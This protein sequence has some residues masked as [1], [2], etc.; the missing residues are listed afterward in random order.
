MLDKTEERAVKTIRFLA[1]ASFATV[2]ASPIH[3]M[4]WCALPDIVPQQASDLERLAPRVEALTGCARQS[5]DSAH[6]A[7][8]VCE[9]DP[10]TD[11]IFEGVHIN[12]F[13][14][15]G[16][17][18]HLVVL[19]MGMTDLDV[20]RRCGQRSV[21]DGDKFVAG[22]VALRDRLSFGFSGPRL[23][24]TSVISEGMSA[25]VSD[26][27]VVGEDD[28]VRGFWQGLHGITAEQYPS[29]SVK[30]AGLSP[31]SS[32]VYSIAQAFQNR[33]STVRQSEEI[34]GTF[35]KWTLS[36]PVGLGGVREVIVEGFVRHVLNADYVLEST[37][38]YERFIGLLDA[39]Y[40]RSERST[41]EGC[42]YRWWRSGRVSIRGEHCPGVSDTL[43]FMNDVAGDQLSQVSQ[44]IEADKAASAGGDDEPTIDDDM[45]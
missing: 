33:G 7:K 29:T 20:L 6:H 24:L 31:V 38:D 35:P 17:S 22:N 42:T 10:S 28:M 14:E 40:G 18:I 9:D 5:T 3:A 11:G 4:N 32:D 26:T 45:F 15:P 44:K 23:T 41:Y 1:L 21:R 25:I 8:W 13:R 37:S 16:Q 36:P 39:E 34:G 19:T 12:Y 27:K 2:L 30:L 43:R